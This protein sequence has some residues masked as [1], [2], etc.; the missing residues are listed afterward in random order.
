[1][2]DPWLDVVTFNA[3]TGNRDLRGNLIDL[4][5]D[6]HKPHAIVLQEVK[7][8]DGT[9]PGYERVA[10]DNSHPEAAS[11]VILVRSRGVDILATSFLRVDGPRWVG[12]KHGE[13]H[14]PRVFPRVSIAAAGFETDLLGVHRTPG[15]PYPNIKVNGESW[16]AEDRA[17]EAWF[18]RRRDRNP[19]RVQAAVGDQN[20]RATDFRDRSVRHLSKRVSGRLLLKGIDGAIIAGAKGKARRLP[21][22]Y[23]SDAHRPVH[24]TLK[25]SR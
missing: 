23:G 21:G 4:A 24:L 1:M 20:D 25:E 6:T 5:D 17:I 7:G 19:D 10:D 14:E 18:A 22:K 12:P 3:W 15:G 8:W 16:A 11:T 13:V 9:I 2:A